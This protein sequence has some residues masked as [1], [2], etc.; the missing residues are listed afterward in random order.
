M[1]K[2]SEGYLI[3]VDI[4]EQD[5]AVVQVVAMDGMKRKLVKQFRGDEAVR[6]YEM[7]SGKVEYELVKKSTL[8]EWD[9]YLKQINEQLINISQRDEIIDRKLK[10]IEENYNLVP[11]E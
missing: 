5:E 10:Y 11:K 7:L 8:L 9:N 1:F 3:G 6:L 4:S 2:V